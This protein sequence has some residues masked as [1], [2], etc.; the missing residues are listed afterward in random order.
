M[1]TVH[2]F[3]LSTDQ[4]IH[5]TSIPLWLP[6]TLTDPCSKHWPTGSSSMPPRA[7][8]KHRHK[9]TLTDQINTCVHQ[10]RHSTPALVRFNRMHL[11]LALPLLPSRPPHLDDVADVASI[12]LLRPS[13]YSRRVLWQ[14][15]S[16]HRRA[17][18]P[19]LAHPCTK[20]PPTPF[21]AS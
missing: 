5:Y 1:G 6:P 10:L 11:S 19:A 2:L 20:S 15:L 12:A 3:S 21:F 13:P 18:R 14:L 9:Q 8:L 16:R 17:Q 7:T 4:S